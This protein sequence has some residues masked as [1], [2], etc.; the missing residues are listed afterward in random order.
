MHIFEKQLHVL[1][2]CFHMCTSLEVGSDDVA[3]SH[4]VGVW[5]RRQSGSGEGS[6]V[7]VAG[8][9]P[10][11]DEVARCELRR[12][13]DWRSLEQSTSPKVKVVRIMK[14]AGETTGKV[15]E[16][17]LTRPFQLRSHCQVSC[18]LGS[19]MHK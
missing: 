6:R 9:R 7:A 19:T 17:T 18:A 1:K 14:A 11:E 12:P 5:V 8:D 15:Y 4:R 2:L 13:S 16:S 3:P 10:V